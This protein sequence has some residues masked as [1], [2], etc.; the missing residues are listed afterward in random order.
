MTMS[1]LAK[2]R[3]IAIVGSL[4]TLALIFLSLYVFIANQIHDT[5]TAS[6]LVLRPTVGKNEYYDRELV[7]GIRK[8]QLFITAVAGS[9]L[10][11]WFF[12]LPGSDKLAVVNHG[13]AGNMAN[14]IYL[15]NAL[16]HA[17]CSVLL[18]DYRGYGLS[19]GEPSIVGV[20]E[21]GL[22]VYDYAVQTLHYPAEKLLLFGES[23]GTGVACDVAQHRPCAAIILESALANIPAVGRNL[24]PFLWLF[25]DMFFAEPHVDNVSAVRKIHVPILF[26]HGKLDHAVPFQ[27]SIELYKNANQPKQ[28]VLLDACGHNDMGAQNSQQFHEAITNFV[29]QYV[30]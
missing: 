15:A 27:H 28:L 3:R 24:F 30:Q 20:M 19:T 8:E 5:K 29:Q 23:I 13:N 25:P 7:S 18:Y 14:R 12:N 2:A 1:S 21:D 11:A 22:S 16:T 26:L 6:F 10:H 17:G 4:V 9:K